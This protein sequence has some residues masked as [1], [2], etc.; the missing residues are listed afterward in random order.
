MR[1]I[2]KIAN[3]AL[4]F[5]LIGVVLPKER[6][7]SGI[8]QANSALRPPMKFGA[9]SA[10]TDKAASTIE[11]RAGN[12]DIANLGEPEKLFDRAFGNFPKFN[13]IRIKGHTCEEWIA[14]KLEIP[15][16]IIIDRFSTNSVQITLYDQFWTVLYELIDNSFKYGSGNTRLIINSYS[17]L[18][19]ISNG[20]IIVRITIGQNRI[21]DADWQELIKDKTGFDNSGGTEYLHDVKRRRGIDIKTSPRKYGLKNVAILMDANPALLRYTRSAELPYQLVTDFYYELPVSRV[22]SLASMEAVGR[23]IK[24][25]LQEEIPTNF[26]LKSTGERLALIKMDKEV[27]RMHRADIVDIAKTL[28]DTTPVE[29]LEYADPKAVNGEACYIAKLDGKVAGYVFAYDDKRKIT[30]ETLG[31]KRD[32]EGKGIANAL[33]WVVTSEAQN[34]NIAVIAARRVD[35]T[36]KRMIE[37]LE[38]HGFRIPEDGNSKKWFDT[39]APVSYVFEKTAGKLANDMLIDIKSSLPNKIGIF[40]RSVKSAL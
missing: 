17:P 15:N 32:K 2:N 26:K 8:A 22:T 24:P 20:K 28:Y 21:N 18:R 1:K 7:L 14:E 11:F 33:V 10:V 5:M 19:K 16:T 9:Q 38:K 4:I 31:V 29:S 12:I 40:L 13:R 39:E 27:F 6:A 25:G 3:I 23:E 36:N 35:P 30:I 37:F 34:R